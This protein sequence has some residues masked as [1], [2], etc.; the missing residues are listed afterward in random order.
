VTTS[1]SSSATGE[2]TYRVFDVLARA[3]E[4]RDR[5]AAA[6][7]EDVDSLDALLVSDVL[8][9]AGRV[10]DTLRLRRAIVDLAAVLRALDAFER[11]LLTAEEL[12]A[13]LAL[14][15]ARTDR[16][17]DFSDARVL[18]R[19]LGELLDHRTDG[20]ALRRQ[21]ELLHRDL[22]AFWLEQL[23]GDP[24]GDVAQHRVS[25]TEPGPGLALDAPDAR[26]RAHDLVEELLHGADHHPVTG[27]LGA[28]WKR[29]WSAVPIAGEQLG[30][31]DQGEVERLAEAVSTIEPAVGE[32][33]LVDLR[34][35]PRWRLDGPDLVL[36]DGLRAARRIEPTRSGIAEVARERTRW[37]VLTTDDLAFAVVEGAGHHA[38]LGPTAFV[39]AACGAPPLEAVARFRE[40]VERLA[41]PEEDPPAD[42]LEVADRFGRLRRRSR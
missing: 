18:L 1:P 26:R 35:A 14:H 39:T 13:G 22:R 31:G 33:L 41:E 11:A 2:R 25:G 8:A 4:A 10:G 20:D 27:L 36:G 30:E 32:L 7:G 12:R 37:C 6:V 42:L 24:A 15:A 9:A 40:H 34:R 28:A 38:L 19:T 16:F 3:G 17:A 29:G 23:T 5:F 21:V